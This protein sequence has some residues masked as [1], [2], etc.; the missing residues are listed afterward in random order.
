MTRLLSLFALASALPLFVACGGD[1]D[2]GADAPSGTPPKT[3][4][5]IASLSEAAQRGYEVWTT[6]S[7]PH[8]AQCHG[9]PLLG[10][11]SAPMMPALETRALDLAKV[12]KA[13]TQGIGIMPAQQGKLSEQQIDDVSAFVVEALAKGK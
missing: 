11:K 6:H 13:V 2:G 4:D 5:P 7:T 9:L 3:N 10:T 12:K 8:C 1:S